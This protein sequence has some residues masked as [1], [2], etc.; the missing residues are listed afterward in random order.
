MYQVTE[1]CHYTTWASREIVCDRNYMEASEFS[2]TLRGHV[3][4]YMIIGFMSGMR[5]KAG[6]FDLTADERGRD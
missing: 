6:T 1:T 2:R 3:P 5:I 4:V